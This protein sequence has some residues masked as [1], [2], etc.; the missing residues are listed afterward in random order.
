MA[1]F[2]DLS[3]VDHFLAETSEPGGEAATLTLPIRGRQYTWRAGEL[4]LWAMLKMRRL[5]EQIAEAGRKAA[6]GEPYASEIAL[7]TVEQRRLDRDLIGEENLASMAED[8]VMW[9]EANHVAATLLTWHLRGHDAALAVWSMKDREVTPD[10]PARAA[11]TKTAGSSTTRK[12]PARTRS[13]GGTS[14]RTGHSSKRTSTASTA[15]T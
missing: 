8:G 12:K 9:P 6:A 1:T 7:T 5:D 15:T 11:S 2:P 10:P 3:S 13:A 14:S 4:S